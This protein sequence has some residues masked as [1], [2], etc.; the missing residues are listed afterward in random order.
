MR[1]E[2]RGLVRR[3]V[4]TNLIVNLGLAALFGFLAYLRFTEGNGLAAILFGVGALLNG[5]AWVRVQ[6][7]HSPVEQA[8]VRAAIDRYEMKKLEVIMWEGKR[9]FRVRL[10]QEAD[11]MLFLELLGRVCPKATPVAATAPAPS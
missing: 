5:L 8:L 9:S 10:P 11:R 4:S 3:L 1:P 7:G 6:L 2:D